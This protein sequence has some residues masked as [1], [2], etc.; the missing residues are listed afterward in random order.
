M[1][2]GPRHMTPEDRR[3]V[4]FAD[5]GIHDARLIIRY[6][7]PHLDEETGEPLPVVVDDGHRG[8]QHLDGK[9]ED[10]PPAEWEKANSLDRYW[11]HAGVRADLTEDLHRERASL[12]LHESLALVMAELATLQHPRALQ[13]RE[14]DARSGVDVDHTPTLEEGIGSARTDEIERRL[15]MIRL[16]VEALWDLLDTHRGYL[17]KSYAMMETWEKDELL[18]GPK[19]RGLTPEEINALHPELGSPRTIRYVRSRK[20]QDARGLPSTRRD[21]TREEDR[22]ILAEDRP[23]DAVLAER[24]GR[25]ENAI[26][27]RRNLVRRREDERAER[28]QAPSSST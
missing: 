20:G 2:N 15:A 1:T 21:W 27:W 16:E 22:A 7:E 3:R 11:N 13:R 23:A 24:L 9:S 6:E 12:R 17:H 5:A 18:T 19:L 4:T 8:L 25:T 10:R 28:E 26:R 14:T